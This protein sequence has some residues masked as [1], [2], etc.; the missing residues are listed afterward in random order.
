MI[1]IA[2]LLRTAIVFFFLS[3]SFVSLH[4]SQSTLE[5]EQFLHFHICSLK[6]DS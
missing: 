4:L 2:K 6:D 5:V 1:N 3:G